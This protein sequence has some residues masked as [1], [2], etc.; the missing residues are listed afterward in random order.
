MEAA[1]KDQATFFWEGWIYGPV[2]Y[3]Y[4]WNASIV[5]IN[6]TAYREKWN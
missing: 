4:W 2:F 1:M 5:E 3:C 6:K